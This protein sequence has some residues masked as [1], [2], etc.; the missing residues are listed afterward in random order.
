MLPEAHDLPAFPSEHPGHLAIA[1]PVAGDLGVPEFPIL[2]RSRSVLRAAV[3]EAAVH[4]HGD[5]GGRKHEV[6]LPKNR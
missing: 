3:P 1:L 5:M 6:R 4:E 2:P